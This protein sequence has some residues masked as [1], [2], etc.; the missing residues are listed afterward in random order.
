MLKEKTTRLGLKVK[1]KVDGWKKRATVA[2]MAVSA[3]ALSAV[4]S[5]AANA[6]LDAVAETLNTGAGDLKTNAMTIITTIIGIFIVVFGIGWL[7]SIFKKKM[8]QAG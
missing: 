8:S 5:F 4:P 7:I 3:F 1:G 6:D 2:S